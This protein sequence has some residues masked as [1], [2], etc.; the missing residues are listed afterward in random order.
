MT[1]LGEAIA[2]GITPCSIRVAEAVILRPGVP[3]PS[4]FLR[5]PH[6]QNNPARPLTFN[7]HPT[8]IPYTIPGTVHHGDG[9][10]ID[11]VAGNS[12]FSEAIVEEIPGAPD[13]VDAFINLN[14]NALTLRC[15]RRVPRHDAHQLKPLVD[16]SDLD[17]PEFKPTPVPPPPP[18]GS[19]CLHFW[20]AGK[21]HQIIANSP[22]TQL[23]DW[24][25]HNYPNLYGPL[26]GKSN[27]QV[28]QFY[29]AHSIRA[30]GEKRIDTSARVMCTALAVYFDNTHK[31][32]RNLGPGSLASLA[33][34]LGA[35]GKAF[36]ARD[37]SDITVIDALKAVNAHAVAGM[38]QTACR[39]IYDDFFANLNE[40]LDLP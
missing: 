5:N 8:A 36:N 9:L 1:V 39:R 14:P 35:T 32:A 29:L 38:I 30:R 15:L 37:H 26:A 23:A 31:F 21:G 22:G 18:W 27:E 24:L 33:V 11:G 40:L 12:A 2:L 16:I 4:L 28:H 10:A 34:H 3:A 19:P 7:T 20:Q 6:S 13:D 25:A 17:L